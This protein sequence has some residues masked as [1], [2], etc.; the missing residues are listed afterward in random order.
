MA[1][2]LSASKEAI[3]DFVKTSEQRH[4]DLVNGIKALKTL[5]DQT[6]ATWSGG[7]RA[8]FDSFMERYYFQADK[9]NDKLLETCENLRNAGKQY[10]EQD[11]DFASQ[12][13]AQVSSLD[14]PAL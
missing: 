14:L 5:E 7:A 9:L 10:D 13:K 4:L 8:A 2:Q 6:T 1:G 11:H 3:D 12:V